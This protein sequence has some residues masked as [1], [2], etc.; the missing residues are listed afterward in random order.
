MD[1]VGSPKQTG[2][3]IAVLEQA[4]FEGEYGGILEEDEEMIAFHYGHVLVD[5][6]VVSSESVHPPSNGFLYPSRDCPGK[7]ESI[8]GVKEDVNTT[9]MLQRSSSS[10]GE[11]IFAIPKVGSEAPDLKSHESGPP[12]CFQNNFKSDLVM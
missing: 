2:D 10:E 6:G 7:G 5:K 4:L 1:Q 11:E 3:D 8:N 9:N 12:L